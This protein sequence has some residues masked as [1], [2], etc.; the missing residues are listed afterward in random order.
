MKHRPKIILITGLSVILIMLATVGLIAYSWISE[1]PSKIVEVN[2]NSVSQFPGA[3]ID[4]GAYY[5]SRLY[6]VFNKMTVAP[7]I[8]ESSSNGMS[9]AS[10][11]LNF[12]A[13]LKNECI[14]PFCFQTRLPFEQI[15][16]DLWKG[17][18][19]IEDFR[20]LNHQGVDLISIARALWADIKAMS[21]VQGGSTLTMQLVKNLFLTQDKAIKRKIKEMVIA[22]YIELTFSKEE[23]LQTYF[24]ET[25]WGS[26][27]GIR[28]KGIFSASMFYFQK[29]P[30]QLSS[31]EVAILVSLLKGPYFYH[32]ISKTDRLKQ[33]V[34]VVVDK[35][36][37]Q[38]LIY[39]PEREVWGDR[40]WD[41]WVKQ[42]KERDSDRI[43]RSLVMSMEDSS[44]EY[45][46]EFQKFALSYSATRT[47]RLLKKR[48]ENEDVGIKVFAGE[49]YCEQDCK[50]YR[51][52]SKVERNLDIGVTKERHQTGS[53]FKPILYNIF[54][55]NGVSLND[56]V[57][58][59]KITLDLISGKWSPRDASKAKVDEIPVREALM[60]SRN[61]PTIRLARD[62]GFEKIEEGLNPYLGEFL[63]RPLGEYPAQL[64]GSIELSVEEVWKVYQKFLRSNC[65]RD[66]NRVNTLINTLSVPSMS[67]IRNVVDPKL[68][69]SRFFG[70]T[71]TTNNGLD[72]WYI[73]FD[74]NQLIVVWMGL[75]GNR[76]DKRLE[77]SGAGAAFRIYQG[78]KL[79]QGKRFNELHCVAEV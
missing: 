16:G 47:K 30:E 42:L 70:K 64:I 52:Y 71:G 37:S 31:Y 21:F 5:D 77:L 10:K 41:Q 26:L 13:L 51:Y 18:I 1:L 66:E 62:I 60:R 78:L 4:E 36:N 11:D 57:S 73:G 45:F 49:V 35:L 25:F 29:R 33:R 19:G 17:L 76:Q 2:N 6:T 46:N 48:I 38:S 63:L 67:T 12:S 69:N 27:Q 68:R 72:S 79:Y 59:D 28:I 65:S 8:H 58:T 75:E 74:G 50:L 39:F 34:K 23:I 9:L 22:L 44:G 14:D 24:N 55:E 7:V 61:R 40:E 43:L 20:F 32:P 54:T 53:I 3:T 56:N 15:P